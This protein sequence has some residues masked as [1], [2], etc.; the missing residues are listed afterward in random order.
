MQ[1][2]NVIGVSSTSP[3]SALVT[4]FYDPSRAFGMLEQRRA[5]WLPLV[6]VTLCTC[7]LYLWYFSVVDFAWLSEQMLAT[8]ADAEK[9]AQ[10]ENVVSK[11]M[12]KG[13]T[14]ATV[15]VTLPLF[16]ALAGL[17]FAIVGKVRNDNFEFGKGFALSLWS[18]V[19]GVLLLVLGGMQILLN[20]GGQFDPS[21][22]NPVSLN[23][24]LFHVNMQNPW[25]GFLDSISV[26]SIWSI[27][28]NVIGYQV[29]AKVSRSTAL[30]VVLAPYVV[31][32]VGWALINLMS[33]AA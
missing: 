2:T 8:I 6:L 1:T 3:F 21:H 26:L 31:V 5:A 17:Y 16:A 7:A 15:I 30:K 22:L 23:Q 24:L 12:M 13:T 14:M 33:K 9:R 4:M 28:L 19:P 25:A 11:G 18:S 10:A 29:W 27:V 32:Y 20:A